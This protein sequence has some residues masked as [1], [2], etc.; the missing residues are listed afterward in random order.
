MFVSNYLVGETTNTY[1]VVLAFVEKYL[2]SSMLRGCLPEWEISHE[3]ISQRPR[4]LGI[5]VVG[6]M[7]NAKHASWNLS[8]GEKATMR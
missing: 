6:P 4:Y 7:F 5:P 3:F 1:V 2:S 8:K